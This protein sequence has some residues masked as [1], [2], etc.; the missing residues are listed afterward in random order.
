MTELRHTN[1]AKGGES[2]GTRALRT[3]VAKRWRWGSARAAAWQLSPERQ[4]QQL[5]NQLDMISVLTFFASSGGWGRWQPWVRLSA[6]DTAAPG[7]SFLSSHIF[8]FVPSE[9]VLSRD[10]N[11][12]RLSKS[13]THAVDY[14]LFG[15]S[16]YG[17]SKRQPLLALYFLV[18]LTPVLLPPLLPLPRPLMSPPRFQ[19]NL[20]EY[21][22]CLIY[23]L[24]I[25][26]SI[27]YF[28]HYSFFVRLSMQFQSHCVHRPESSKHCIILRKYAQFQIRNEKSLC[29]WTGQ[30]HRWGDSGRAD[31]QHL[32]EEWRWEYYSDE[33]YDLHATR[34]HEY[35]YAW[36]RKC[37]R[38]AHGN[39][40]SEQ[41]CCSRVG[42]VCRRFDCGHQL[43]EW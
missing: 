37:V 23:L 14:V 31:L 13:W 33:S 28:L 38:T 41:Q 1:S 29:L 39:T 40:G 20:C 4:P 7:K 42:A 30:E 12:G 5:L 26:F 35:K 27:D 43:H 10:R 11:I 32:R 36:L 18:V 34:R 3:A 25:D 19:P 2:D 21:A 8:I 22:R 9:C 24:L 17:T 15:V 6:R 16:I